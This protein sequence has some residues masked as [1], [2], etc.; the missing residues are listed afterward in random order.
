MP[1]INGNRYASRHV[2]RRDV[3]EEIYKRDEL[4]KQQINQMTIHLI[5]K[6]DKHR[7]CCIMM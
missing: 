3:L 1:T 5:K 4:R 7:D 6:E 2:P